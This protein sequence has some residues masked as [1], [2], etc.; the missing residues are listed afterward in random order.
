MHKSAWPSLLRILAVSYAASCVSVG[1]VDVNSQL[2][3]DLM[4][5]MTLEEKVGQLELYSRPS[6]SDFNGQSIGWNT[7]VKLIRAGQVG[8][9]FNGAG[10]AVNRE[11]QRIAVEESRLGIPMIFGADIWHGMWTIFPA[12]LAEA[13][14]W[15]PALA[16][17]TARATAKE[18]TASGLMWTFSPMVDTARDQRWGR[19]IE[20]AGEDPFLGEAICPSPR[21]GL[22]GTGL[23]VRGQP[24]QLLEALRRVRRC[25]G[26]A[27]LQ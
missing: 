14:S 5:K 25:A 1:A 8:A 10:V 17:R 12:P 18:S 15:E 21:P 27:G 4:A 24:C 9:L 20:G 6:G 26:W 23:E 2:V 19:N 13:A 3:E 7:T 11:L 22:P 16:R